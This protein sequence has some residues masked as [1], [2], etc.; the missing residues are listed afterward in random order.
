MSCKINNIKRKKLLRNDFNHRSSAKFLS[1]VYTF[2]TEYAWGATA[3]Y[4]SVYLGREEK[5][6]T[7]QTKRSKQRENLNNAR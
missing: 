3:A 7:L 4:S 5:Y 2:L 6:W 1:K